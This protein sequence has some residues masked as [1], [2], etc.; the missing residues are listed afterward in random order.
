[1]TK[2]K[3]PVGPGRTIKQERS[4]KTFNALV[5]TGF[6]LLQKNEFESLTIAG[7][8][9]SAGYSVGAF[10]ARF[11]GK[12]EFF[13]ALV[14]QHLRDRT[15]ARGRLLVKASR[16]ALIDTLIDDLVTSY[17]RR[18]GFWRAVLMRS[19]HDAAFFAPISQHGRVWVEDVT[20][21]IQQDA[22]RDL[23]EV[24]RENI[25]FALH[26]VLGMINNRIVNR[27]RPSLLG[28]S[29]FVRNLTRAFRL[30]SDYE[31]LMVRPARPA[32]SRRSVT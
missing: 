3:L 16:E 32:R 1:M 6:K 30:V 11:K 21:R 2:V 13:A 23:T 31:A 19:A 4:R 8:C 12:D 27:P 9:R 24:E 17:W 26:M 28:H 14:E 20:E 5:S 18:R 25:R 10:Y 7:I 29:S 15:S 22:G